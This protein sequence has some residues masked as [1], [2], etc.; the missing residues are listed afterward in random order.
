MAESVSLYLPLQTYVNVRSFTNAAFTQRVTLVEEDGTRHQ[1][2]GSGEHDTPM[3]GGSFAI[4]TPAS[5]K[6]PRGYQ[7]T[8]N[9]DSDQSGTWRP[10]SLGQG[11]CGV[12]FYH[13]V[14]VVSEDYIDNDWNDCVVQFTWW[15]PPPGRSATDRRSRKKKRR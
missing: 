6:S 12:M 5:A 11:S 8:I 3:P 14:M 7:V 1:Y 15:V 9:V 10:S 4:R 2:E 13:L